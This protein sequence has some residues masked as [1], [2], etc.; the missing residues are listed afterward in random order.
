[1]TSNVPEFIYEYEGEYATEYEVDEDE[2]DRDVEVDEYEYE[3]KPLSELR[4]VC[5]FDYNGTTIFIRADVEDVARSIS[6]QRVTN[7][8]QRNIVDLEVEL[9]HQCFFIFQFN[10]HNWTTII[11]RNRSI[12]EDARLISLSLQTRAIYYG[13]SDTACALE[14][15]IYENG[16]LVEKLETGEC[17]KNIEWRSSI[18]DPDTG[19]IGINVGVEEWI[20]QLFYE[21]DVLEPSMTF[22]DFVGYV[23]YKPGHKIVIKDPGNMFKSIDIVTI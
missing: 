16:E 8:W 3:R 12:D 13:I 21:N 5:S 20:E 18:H 10:G 11:P 6:E 23:S 17:Y 2:I 7:K 1:M 4:G 9:S 22:V 14:Y 15:S 19:R